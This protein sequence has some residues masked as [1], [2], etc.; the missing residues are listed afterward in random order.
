M[1]LEI[2]MRGK[3]HSWPRSYSQLAYVDVVKPVRRACARCRAAR[4][5]STFPSDVLT[6]KPGVPRQVR[7]ALEIRRQVASRQGG[8][9]A[10]EMLVRRAR[11]PAIY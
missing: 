2:F 5:L 7:A 1:V 9:S 10:N 3:Q 4:L 11:P 6:T 8:R